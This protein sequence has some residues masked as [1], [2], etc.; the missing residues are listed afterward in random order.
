MIQTK[1]TLG[2]PQL[3]FLQLFKRYGFKDRSAVVR[4]ALDR[5]RCELEM[6]E[7]RQS[8]VIY[9]E[10]YETDQA[11]QGITDSALQGWPE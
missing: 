1:F 9:A 5:L 6:E 4:A 8:A 10:L 11:L 2:E 7:L 3:D